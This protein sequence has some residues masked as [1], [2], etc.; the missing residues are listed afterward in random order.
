MK[1]CLVKPLHPLWVPCQ[2]NSFEKFRECERGSVTQSNQTKLV[3]FIFVAFLILLSFHL[4]TL[5]TDQTATLNQLERTELHQK[6]S[7]LVQEISK[8]PFDA[9]N[10]G[11]LLNQWILRSGIDQLSIFDPHGKKISDAVSGFNRNPTT[12]EIS[13]EDRHQI[14]AGSTIIR[15]TEHEGIQEGNWII[16]APIQLQN[17]E[18]KGI[19]RLEGRGV[20]LQHLE[21]S[22]ITSLLL[23]LFGFAA[24]FVLVYSFIRTGMGFLRDKKQNIV[25]PITN[26]STTEN[27]PKQDK[28]HF[29]M[30]TF[31]SVVHQLKEKEQALDHLRTAAEEKVRDIESYNENILR[32]VS[33]GVITF[34]PDGVITTFNTAAEKILGFHPD[35][36]VGQSCE[37]V[38]GPDHPVFHL[39]NLAIQSEKSTAR[40]E[41]EIHRS[42]HQKIWVGVST[43]LLRDQKDT[44]IGTT[45]VFSDLTEIRRLHQQIELKKRLSELGEMS[46]GIAHEFR[47][48][49][50]TIVGFAKLL[51]KQVEKQDPKQKMIEAII[52]ELRDMDQLIYD[53][54]SFS[55]NTE[56]HCQ[57]FASSPFLENI[58]EKLTSLH[59]EHDAEIITNFS[60]NLPPIYGDELLLRQ[61]FAN[62][63]QNGLEAMEDGGKLTVS[64]HSLPKSLIEIVIQ[65]SG[66][67]IP[68][69]D[70][71]KIFLPF[72]T[73]K[74]KGTGLGLAL[75]HKIILSHNGRIEVESQEGK[76]TAFHIYLP[77]WETHPKQLDTLS[78]S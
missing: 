53:L 78:A 69:E 6:A 52:L 64:A 23:K 20:T 77:T 19:L 41:F 14:L 50:G 58:L 17:Q 4:W 57:A 71:D 36:V 15:H 5:L 39:L 49:M 32:S 22:A 9:K 34:N 70:Q 67:G 43:S 73:T 42:D 45:F 51:S 11:P 72:F 68:K 37:S 66:N 47:N 63:V 48:N 76:G 59:Q 26:T 16:Y 74:K 7:F 29:V 13:T 75:V 18:V 12:L 46:A 56:I 8:Q 2:K 25:R 27:Y 40:Q 55:K 54:L 31:Q 61:A 10:L 3:L 30:D 44:L 21:K 33:S 1:Q 60:K 28:A 65:D 38:F 35:Q 24:A 62:L